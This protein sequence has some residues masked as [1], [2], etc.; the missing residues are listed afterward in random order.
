MSSACPTARPA[1][2]SIAWPSAPAHAVVPT[3]ALWSVLFLIS[4]LCLQYGVAR[5]PANITAV[6][7][8][9]EIIVAALS[10]WLIGT[11]ELRPQDLIGGVLIISAPWL[12]RDKRAVVPAH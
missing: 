5:L 12:I 4:N 11:A 7:M 9:F 1:C 6:V 10:S 8:L 3:L 2:G